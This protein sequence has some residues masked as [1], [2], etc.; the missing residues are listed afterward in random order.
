MT[1]KFLGP[2]EMFGE[3]EVIKAPDLMRQFSV[4]STQEQNRVYSV[5]KR[6]F[7]RVLQTDPMLGAG[8]T[9]LV[10][11]KLRQILTQIK[12]YEKNFID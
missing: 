9:L 4:I 2:G 12:V 5:S 1:L 7:I 11:S 6:D 3:L 8:L 10:D